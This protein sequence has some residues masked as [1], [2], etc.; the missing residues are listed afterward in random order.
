[1]AAA[2]KA[3]IIRR[4]R[5][6]STKGSFWRYA[7]CNPLAMVAGSDHARTLYVFYY[8]GNVTFN[9]TLVPS[10]AIS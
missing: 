4:R 1:M 10:N 7:V 3:V 6:R 9:S 2:L 8:R 5:T